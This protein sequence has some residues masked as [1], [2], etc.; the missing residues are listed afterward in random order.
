MSEITAPKECAKC[1]AI[2]PAAAVPKARA[3]GEEIR[4][5]VCGAELKE[6][7]RGDKGAAWSR[8]DTALWFMSFP[9]AEAILAVVA[10]LGVV[11]L[12]VAVK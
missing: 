11:G 5:T 12:V 7:V 6:L 8:R 4:C 1:G 9:G 3:P 10:I 2:F